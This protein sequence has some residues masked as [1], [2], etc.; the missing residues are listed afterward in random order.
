[1]CSLSLCRVVS[2]LV[3]APASKSRAETHEEIGQSLLIS[4]GV[5][6]LVT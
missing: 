4:C 6:K 3:Q 2:E 1:M 5:L